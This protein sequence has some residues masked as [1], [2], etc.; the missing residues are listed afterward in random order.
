MKLRKPSFDTLDSINK[1][2]IISYTDFHKTRPINKV[3]TRLSPKESPRVLS[4]KFPLR[5][6]KKQTFSLSPSALRSSLSSDI[7]RSFDTTTHI[8]NHSSVGGS[9]ASS[10]GDSIAIKTQEVVRGGFH[11]LI[12]E[13]INPES[14]A[15]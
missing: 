3:L 13:N 15:S 4:S 9:R 8:Y 12:D 10:R 11:R 14:V 7:R 1:P 2:P 6:I 5:N